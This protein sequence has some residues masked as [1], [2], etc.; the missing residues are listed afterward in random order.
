MIG[1]ATNHLWQTTLFA[2]AVG[3]LTLAFRGHAARVRYWLW[4]SASCKFLIPFALL[5]TLG[6]RLERDARPLSSLPAVVAPLIQISQPFS[7]APLPAGSTQTALHWTDAWTDAAIISVW[8]CG[9][10][11]VALMRFRGWLRIRA[12]LHASTP[13]D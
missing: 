7:S 5:M 13:I 11:A 10:L 8:A 1:E 12:A 9:F 3:V 6:S 4:F 2:I